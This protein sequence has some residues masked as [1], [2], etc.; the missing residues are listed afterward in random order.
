MRIMSCC[1]HS[2][3]CWNADRGFALCSKSGPSSTATA[4]TAPRT[5]AGS[6]SPSYDPW[7]YWNAHRSIDIRLDC[8]TRYPLDCTN[9]R[10]EHGGVLLLRCVSS[11]TII[12]RRRIHDSFG[13][14]NCGDCGRSLRV[15]CTATNRGTSSFQ[16]IVAWPRLHGF[17]GSGNYLNPHANLCSAVW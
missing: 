14:S 1:L 8:S 9:I 17:C 13:I 11:L 2:V 4:K 7:F 15:R 16:Q 10:V 3:R 6:P 5:Q 12:S